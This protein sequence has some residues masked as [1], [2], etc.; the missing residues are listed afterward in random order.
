MRVATQVGYSP[1]V[2]WRTEKKAW[3]F[4][5]D[6]R[7]F[8]LTS[9]KASANGP[10][11]VQHMSVI[12]AVSPDQPLFQCARN[13]DHTSDATFA[14]TAVDVLQAPSTP[15]PAEPAPAAARCP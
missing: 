2:G 5:V 1:G 14:R 4:N 15:P 6:A 11:P 8:S 7:D 3:N 13:D 10:Q 12:Q 9:Q